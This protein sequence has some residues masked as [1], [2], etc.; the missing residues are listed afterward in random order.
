MQAHPD[1]FWDIRAHEQAEEDSISRQI[2]SLQKAIEMGR[3]V[4]QIRHAP[5][6][7]EFLDATK[8]LRDAAVRKLVTDGTFTNEGLRE[9]RG[10][11]NGLDDVIALMTRPQLVEA[12]AE[13]LAQCETALQQVR[14]RRP[15]AKAKDP[16]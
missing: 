5:G 4:A 2:T 11:V 6:F 12:L 10:R 16:T 9:Q 13:K 15:A 3:R 8:D 14:S 1:S 7:K